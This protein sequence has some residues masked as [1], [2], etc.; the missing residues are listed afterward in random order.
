MAF[1]YKINPNFAKFLKNHLSFHTK[2][3]NLKESARYRAKLQKVLYM[4][5]HTNGISVLMWPV[6]TCVS[7]LYTSAAHIARARLTILDRLVKF[8]L[9]R[10]TLCPHILKSIPLLRLIFIFVYV[11]FLAVLVFLLVFFRIAF[12]FIFDVAVF[13]FFVAVFAAVVLFILFGIECILPS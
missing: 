1:K 10:S 7:Y 2:N 4:F 9:L 6:T 12:L 3:E 8:A 11:F 5:S 13:A